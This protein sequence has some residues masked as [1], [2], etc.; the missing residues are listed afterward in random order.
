M[1][2]NLSSTK[3]TI[4]RSY[5]RN[6]KAFRSKQAKPTQPNGFNSRVHQ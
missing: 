5:S 6:E 3:R 4:I 2:N 1:I